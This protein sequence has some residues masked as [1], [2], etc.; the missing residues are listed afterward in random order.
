MNNSLTLT[1]SDESVGPPD[2]ARAPRH[3]ASPASAPLSALCLIA[4]LHH[5]AADPA[6]LAHQLG[7]PASHVPDARDLLLAAKHLGLK[8]RRSR[9]AIDR[10]GLVPLP[11][12]A[13]MSAPKP[14][15]PAVRRGE[16]SSPA[17]PDLLKKADTDDGTT[18]VVMLAQCDGQRVLFMD[19]AAAVTGHA[20]RPTIEPLAVFATQWS[21][22]LI[23]IASRASLAGALAKFDFSWF[24]PSLVKYRRLFG[25]VLVVSLFL[26]LFALA[27]PLFFQRRR[28]AFGNQNQA[29]S[30]PIVTKIVTRTG[31]VF[32]CLWGDIRFNMSG[33]Y[34]GNCGHRGLDNG[35]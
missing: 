30:S 18:R 10:L 5:I 34:A 12:L 22:E 20:A 17:K 2:E 32:H 9:S 23:L 16:L 31:R 7:W 13:L 4:R 33:G 24:I 29:R 8:A 27:S 14:A 35:R 25:E 19:P 11:A 3:G 26:Q 28:L 15:L 6:H 21:G 1:P